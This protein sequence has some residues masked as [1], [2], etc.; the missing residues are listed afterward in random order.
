MA[1]T[2]K[3]LQYEAIEE[4]PMLQRSV[5]HLQTSRASTSMSGM[6]IH[7]ASFV[8]LCSFFVAEWM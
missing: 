1:A 3:K 2:S 8:S 5:E 6:T 4:E 7:L